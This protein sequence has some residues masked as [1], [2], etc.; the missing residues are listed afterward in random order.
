M[1]RSMIVLTCNTPDIQSAMSLYFALM[2]LSPDYIIAAK[3]FILEDAGFVIHFM[4]SFI[5]Q[6][7]DATKKLHIHFKMLPL[8]MH[9]TPFRWQGSFCGTCSTFSRSRQLADQ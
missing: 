2:C 9:D 3:D 1:Q 6:Q 8:L 5:V 7:S 4:E